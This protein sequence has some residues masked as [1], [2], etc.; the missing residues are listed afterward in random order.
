MRYFIVGNINN[1][2]AFKF[3]IFLGKKN[4]SSNKRLKQILRQFPKSKLKLS[5]V[6]ID[7]SGTVLKDGLYSSKSVNNSVILCTNKLYYKI[8]KVK[9]FNGNIK[10]FAQELKRL[11]SFYNYP[12]SSKLLNIVVAESQSS[13]VTQLSI[14]DVLHKC[15]G[16]QMS[17]SVI[18]FPFLNKF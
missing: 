14:N 9:K 8:I 11:T 10:I 16:F 1:F 5:T 12:I 18:I 2:S 7:K 13:Q 4:R 17:N 3:E 15:C 6:N